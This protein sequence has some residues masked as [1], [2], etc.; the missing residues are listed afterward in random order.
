MKGPL[1]FLAVIFT[2]TSCDSPR[3]RRIVSSNSGIDMSTVTTGRTTIPGT[4]DT[5]GTTPGTTPTVPATTAPVIPADAS[6]CH[7]ATDGITGFDGPISTHLGNYTLCQSSTDKN[8]MYFQIQN[9]PKTTTTPPTDIQI[10]FIPTMS[11]GTNSIYVG[12]PMCGVFNSATTV[13]KITFVKF[14]AYQN[15]VINGAIFF[16][17]LAFNYPYPFNN[18]MQTMTLDAYRICM[19]AISTYPYNPAYCQAFKQVNQYVYKQF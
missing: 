12:N 19:Q 4:T 16:K 13:R 15:A 9:P 1:F 5:T 14:P 8:I 10:C 6:H 17:D 18:Y 2:L 11:S 7:F 3:D